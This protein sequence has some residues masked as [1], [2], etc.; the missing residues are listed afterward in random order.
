[1]A[2]INTNISS[3]N[4]QNNLMKSQNELQ[5]SLQ[6]LSSGLRINSAKDDAAGLAI[7]DRFTAQIRGLN[8]ATRNANDGISLAQTAEGAM[9]ESTNILQRM[10]ELAI[11]SANDTNSASDRASLQKEVNQLQQELER[12]ATTTS[13]NGKTLLDGGF[14]AQSF[15]IGANANQTIDVSI[16]GARTRDL[17]NNQVGSDAIAAVAAANATAA[18]SATLNGIAQ[19]TVSVSGQFGSANINIA[20]NSSAK[21]I[22]EAINA[23]TEDTGVSANAR[24]SAQIDNFTASGSVSFD[25]VGSN[26]EAVRIA[27]NVDNTD[28]S[29]LA[30]AIND[31][32]GRTGITATLNSERTAIVLESRTGED[33]KLFNVTSSQ[34]FEFAT[35]DADG[36]AVGTPV[37]MDAGTPSVTAAGRLEFSSDKSFTVESTGTDIIS[38]IKTSELKSVDTI[39]IGT[40]AG[41]NDAISRLDG[42]LAQI[43]DSRADL[44]AVMNRFESTIAN[45]SSISENLSAA[46]SRIL[47]ADFAQETA[48]LTRNQILQQAGTTILAQANQLPQSVLSLLG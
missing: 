43:A 42:A 26:A 35:L 20:S 15:Q 1:M 8:Q 29:E 17:G 12:I 45:L 25:I 44:G 24:T 3:I 9:Q 16:A 28:L 46:R 37:T 14:V 13:F 7:S 18:A 34:D 31:V 38:A 27:S 5:T 10:R 6:R 40:Q 22:A 48:N 23:R 30:K 36:A 47:D 39:D 11:Q 21:A 32:S 19:Q 4:A 2:V 33:I 41:A